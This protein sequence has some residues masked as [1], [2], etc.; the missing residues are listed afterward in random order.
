MSKYWLDPSYCVYLV[1]REWIVHE[2]KGSARDF[3]VSL[4]ANAINVPITLSNVKLHSPSQTS[5][6]D[7]IETESHV[8][9]NG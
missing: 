9:P 8:L 3:N 1:A 6:I 5:N 4:T 7:L 2:M